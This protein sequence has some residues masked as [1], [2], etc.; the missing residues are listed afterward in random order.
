MM[1]IY[2]KDAGGENEG[3][4]HVPCCPQ[5]GSVLQRPNGKWLAVV[6]FVYS[7]SQNVEVLTVPCDPPYSR[8]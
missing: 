7:D 6:G 1:L 2:L 8:R 4:M 3:T 5:R